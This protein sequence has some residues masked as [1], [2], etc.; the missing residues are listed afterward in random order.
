MIII[1]INVATVSAVE[2]S[3]QFA[4]TE[5]IRRHRHLHLALAIA[6]N[7]RP[8][9]TTLRPRGRRHHHHGQIHQAVGEGGEVQVESEIAEPQL[10]HRVCNARGCIGL[11]GHQG[12]GEGRSEDELIGREMRKSPEPDDLSTHTHAHTHTMHE[13]SVHAITGARA[14]E[15]LSF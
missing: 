2:A 11:F 15:C 1:T 6:H 8:G 3:L 7:Q 9:T 12:A 13:Q 5:T 4:Q 14:C 10:S